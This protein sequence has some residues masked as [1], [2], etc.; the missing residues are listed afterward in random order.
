MLQPCQDNFSKS[1]S[2]LHEMMCY[3]ASLEAE[4]KWVRTGVNKLQVAPLD[5]SAPLYLDSSAFAAGVSREAICDTAQNLGLAIKLNGA[6][7]PLRDTAYKGLLDRAKISGSSL[8]KLG[9]KPLAGMLNS[10]LKL[11]PKAS[12][13]VLV[14]GEKVSAT[15]SED[16]HD[17]SILEIHELLVKLAETL[18]SRFSGHQFEGGYTDHA[19]TS[20]AWSLPAQREKLLGSYEK[21]LD[22]HGKSSMVSKLM[23]G[24]QFTTSDTGLS[25]AKVAAVLVG[26]QHPI[27]IGGMLST[28]HRWK[29]SVK[30][31][32]KELYNLFAQFGNA[33]EKLEKLES[34]ELEYPINAMTR[35]CKKLALPKKEAINAIHMFEM[36]Y[37]GGG[38]TAHDVFMAMQEIPFLL[39]TQGCP[40]S[41]LIILGENMARALSLDWS[42]FDLAK[43]VDY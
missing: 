15:H 6:Y 25:S 20:A 5:E 37:G 23:P 22:A 3:H 30:D 2:T 13:L 18:D 29:R 35:V 24:I 7:Y 21:L 14:R 33:L 42:N 12:T 17:Y 16:E 8:N 39:K 31:F 34:I 38:A 9:R 41:K 19:F 11:Y 28:E 4:S 40:E 1:F 26:G 36:A 32:S 43:A 27:Y 10:C